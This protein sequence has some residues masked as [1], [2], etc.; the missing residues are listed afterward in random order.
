MDRKRFAEAYARRPSAAFFRNLGSEA[1]INTM[2]PFDEWG[3]I[4]GDGLYES[5]SGDN[6]Q[7]F[8]TGRFFGA[9]NGHVQTES[10]AEYRGIIDAAIV[11]AALDNEDDARE[12]AM[13]VHNFHV[14]SQP[15]APM[16]GEMIAGLEIGQGDREKTIRLAMLAL[17]Q[18]SLDYALYRQ[19]FASIEQG[20]SY[21]DES[22]RSMRG[23][24]EGIMTE[25]DAFLT[26]LEIARTNPNLIVVPAPRRFEHST[27]ETN[28]DFI[29][30]DKSTDEA[31]GVQVKSYITDNDRELFDGERIVLIS[32][33]D[34]LGGKIWTR[35]QSGSSRNQF[36]TWPGMIAAD[37]LKN[38]PLHGKKNTG[39]EFFDHRSLLNLRRLAST[40][41]TPP[42]DTRK[43]IRGSLQ[44]SK[45]KVSSRLMPFLRQDEDT[46]NPGSDT[47]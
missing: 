24:T 8:D 6:R 46:M 41:L 3:D 12:K 31:V 40:L 27:R 7:I 44:Q 32:G 16:W 29:A 21:F 17:S 25:I 42:Y 20:H 11:N 10:A 1:I 18:R 23:V 43:I 9:Y 37:V 19:K 13:S 22:T 26:L 35:T 5:L 15:V 14:M 33:S 2:R 38:I 28:A 45:H 34:D 30:Y 4:L 39:N 36:V 47:L